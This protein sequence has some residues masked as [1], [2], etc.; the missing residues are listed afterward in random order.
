MLSVLCLFCVGGVWHYLVSGQFFSPLTSGVLH[1]SRSG[2]G[3]GTHF[4]PVWALRS[5]APILLGGVCSWNLC[6]GGLSRGPEG[7]QHIR[8]AL[9]VPSSWGAAPD[10]CPFGP[11]D[12][13]QGPLSGVLSLPSRSEQAGAS[14]PRRPS[15][16]P[17]PPRSLEE[18]TLPADSAR[19]EHHRTVPGRPGSAR[20]PP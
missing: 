12:S 4:G 7:P 5:A 17:S 6:P 19:P 15:L 1:L 13:L 9:G 18:Q 14:H 11:P 3:K 16:V 2:W 20:R 10:F 8:T